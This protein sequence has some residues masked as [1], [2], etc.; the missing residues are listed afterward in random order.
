[1]RAQGLGFGAA[2]FG[3]R[4]EGFGLR[5]YFGFR[6]WGFGFCDW[7][8]HLWKWVA[9]PLLFGIRGLRFRSF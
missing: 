6:V 9:G 7:V 4:V 8:L 3:M 2:G 1:M 5:A